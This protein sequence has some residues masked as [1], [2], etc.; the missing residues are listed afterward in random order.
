MTART[1]APV[2]MFP[3][4]YHAHWDAVRGIAGRSCGPDD[5]QD[6]AQEVFLRVWRDPDR[7]D[8][9]R[10]SMRAYLATMTRAAAIDRLRSDG[11][12]RS[13][14][15]KH[16]APTE[17]CEAGGDRLDSEMVAERVRHALAQLSPGESDAIIAA[18]FGESTY[19]DVAI[20]LEIPEGTV[21]SRIR[22]GLKKLQIALKDI[23]A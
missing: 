23:Q 6:V 11:A 1:A 8:V 15:I 20:L 21:K 16:D 14:E 9:R 22:S 13:R 5:A 18:F 12:R 10:G 17:V 2:A 4:V 19:R 3:A 7:F